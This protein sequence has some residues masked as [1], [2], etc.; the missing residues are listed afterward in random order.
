MIANWRAKENP[1]S[2]HWHS[3][4]FMFKEG[5]I[6]SFDEA[7][8]DLY[9]WSASDYDISTTINHSPRLT[10]DLVQI[11]KWESIVFKM[12]WETLWYDISYTV[13]VSV[14]LKYTVVITFQWRG[15]DTNVSDIEV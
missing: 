7:R 3:L 8:I 14:S 4:L 13:F 5:E 10:A 15:D 9:G 11:P 12:L 6:R 1:C 2:Q